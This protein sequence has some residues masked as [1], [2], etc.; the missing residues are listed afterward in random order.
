MNQWRNIY[1]RPIGPDSPRRFEIVNS[2]NNC[3]GSDSFETEAA[4]RD[5]LKQFWRGV[6]GID[7][8]K[9]AVRSVSSILLPSELDART[10]RLLAARET[11][12]ADHA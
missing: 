5:E 12:E 1:T 2:S 6:S 7:L 11:T 4:A 8:S 3:W 10:A 9:F